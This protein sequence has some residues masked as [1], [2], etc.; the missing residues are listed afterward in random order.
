[1][2]KKKIIGN[3]ALFVAMTSVFFAF[4]LFLLFLCSFPVILLLELAQDVIGLL[5]ESG[6]QSKISYAGHLG[7]NE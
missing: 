7:G 6:R 4:L 1:M 5:T 2:N 3:F